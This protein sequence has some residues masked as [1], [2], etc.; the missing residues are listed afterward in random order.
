[1]MDKEEAIKAAE[2]RARNAAAAKR[3]RLFKS[4]K[5]THQLQTL[6]HK[7]EDLK[8]KNE[9]LKHKNEDLKHENED[10]KRKLSTQNGR[11]VCSC[12]GDFEE[13]VEREVRRRMDQMWEVDSSGLQANNDERNE[14][15]AFLDSLLLTP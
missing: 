5:Q 3:S 14:D 6:K 1:M 13:R 10:L 11:S 7:N 8:H 12:E 9:D 2:R 4:E 15:C